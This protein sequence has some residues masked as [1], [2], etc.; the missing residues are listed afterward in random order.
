MTTQYLLIIAI[1]SPYVACF[2]LGHYVKHLHM[3]QVRYFYDH[4]KAH[5][6]NANLPPYNLRDK[7]FPG[8][9]APR[10][11]KIFNPRK[12]L[13]EKMKGNVLDIFE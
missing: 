2:L 4:W 11:A 13:D 6:G 10:K 9:D 3:L 12:I 5:V 1:L 8:K 7:L